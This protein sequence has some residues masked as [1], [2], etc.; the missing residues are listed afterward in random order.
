MYLYPEKCI[1]FN[2]SEPGKKVFATTSMLWAFDIS[3]MNYLTLYRIHSL[4]YLRS[5]TFRCKNIGI[6]KARFVTKTQFL[7]NFA[8]HIRLLYRNWMDPLILKNQLWFLCSI[9]KKEWIKHEIK[10]VHIGYLDYAVEIKGIP[11]LS[12]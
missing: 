5:L 1:K 2:Q 6:R 7:R 9:S 8:R 3:N 4:L 12:S 11:F 10:C